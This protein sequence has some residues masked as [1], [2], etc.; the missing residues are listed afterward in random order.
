MNIKIVVESEQKRLRIIDSITHWCETTK[1]EHLLRPFDIPGLAMTIIE[2]FYPV[3]MCCG[4][5]VKETTDGEHI[6]F[7]ETDG[8]D[9]EEVSGMYCKE[10]ADVYVDYYG[11]W[12]LD[13]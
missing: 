4:H 3:R 11:A 5:Y 10:C 7:K 13:R 9:S 6:A 1:V 12:R 2:E 8:P